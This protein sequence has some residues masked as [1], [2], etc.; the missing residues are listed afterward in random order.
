ML[1]GWRSLNIASTSDGEGRAVRLRRNESVIDFHRS[2]RMRL[3][4]T[5]NHSGLRLREVASFEVVGSDIFDV[6]DVGAGIVTHDEMLRHVPKKLE[7]S[8]REGD[9]MRFQAA[10]AARVS[11]KISSLDFALRLVIYDIAAE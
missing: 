9:E 7:N 3:D 1:A 10:D 8:K 4:D 11:F 6:T 5:L 2:R